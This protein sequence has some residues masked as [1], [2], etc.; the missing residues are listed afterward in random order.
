M[1]VGKRKRADGL[2]NTVI[3]KL[4]IELHLPGYQYCGPGTKLDKRLARGDPGVNPLDVQCKLHDISYRD[5]SDLENR[6]KADHRLEQSAWSRLKSSDATI[7]ERISALAVGSI[8]KAKRKL[9]MGAKISSKRKNMKKTKNM[10][11]KR[12]SLSTLRKLISNGIKKENGNVAQT[13]KSAVVTAKQAVK[14]LGGKKNISIPRII[15]VPKEGGFLPFLIPLFAGLSAV[16][17][18][19]GGASGIAKAVNDTKNA[20]KLQ[21]ETSRHNRT[22][23]AIAIGNNKKDGGGLHLKPYK[24]S[25]GGALYLKPYSK[26]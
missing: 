3:N 2:L 1:L 15:P 16:G 25:G 14:A 18:L 24:A 13:I 12:G 21:E 6:H 11:R 7:G 23:E 4:P 5:N 19:A 26:N 20:Q 9:G 10:T 22:M 17:A 8:M